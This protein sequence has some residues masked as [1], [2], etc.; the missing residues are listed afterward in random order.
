MVNEYGNHVLDFWVRKGLGC[1]SGIS[2]ETE[3]LKVHWYG[4]LGSDEISG[5]KYKAIYIPENINLWIYDN[6]VDSLA[7]IIF[8][9]QLCEPAIEPLSTTKCFTSPL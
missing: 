6:P 7:F 1:T 5:A 3:T 9:Y 4:S 2:R 8:T